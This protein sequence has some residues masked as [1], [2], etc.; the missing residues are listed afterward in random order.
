MTT[1]GQST[2]ASQSPQEII[3]SAGAIYIGIQQTLGSPLYCFTDPVTG[4]SL[5]LYARDM[6]KEAVRLIMRESRRAFRAGA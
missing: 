2:S 5:G 6:S 1:A 4:T 3:E